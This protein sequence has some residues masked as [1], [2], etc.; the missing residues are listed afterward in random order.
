MKPGASKRTG[1]SEIA[2]LLFGEATDIHFFVGRAMNEAHQ[3]PKLPIHFSIKM[4]LIE[5]LVDCLKQMGKTVDGEATIKITERKRI[6]TMR[7]FD[8]QV[9]YLEYKVLREVAR[10]AWDD[11]LLAALTILPTQLSRGRS[12]PCAAV[13]IK[14]ARL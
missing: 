7:K 8:T 14:S 3:N 1:R 10:H 6:D 2:R 11:T 5:D 9:Q 4:R 13:S 12:Q